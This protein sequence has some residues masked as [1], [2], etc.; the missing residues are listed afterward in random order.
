MSK[1]IRCSPA[2][3][4][5]DVGN[6]LD[7]IHLC[8]S[9]VKLCRISVRELMKIK[10]YSG[11]VEYSK[12]VVTHGGI[13]LKVIIH[14]SLYICKQ[15]SPQPFQLLVVCFLISHVLKLNI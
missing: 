11:T 5:P 3:F 6:W 10:S 12:S 14:K 7:I 13:T 9:A 2:L 4:I 15:F 8:Y 1:F